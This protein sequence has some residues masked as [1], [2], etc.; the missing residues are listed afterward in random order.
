MKYYNVILEVTNGESVV[1]H[2]YRKVKSVLQL[3]RFVEAK[4]PTVKVGY[5]NVYDYVTKLKLVS[6][7]D[8]DLLTWKVKKRL[9][10]VTFIRQTAV[11]KP[12]SENRSRNTVMD[13]QHGTNAVNDLHIKF[14]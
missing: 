12:Q 6:T 2:K 14:I 4:N 5:I 11:G 9:F 10:F 1:F 8:R 3:I 13:T 7:K